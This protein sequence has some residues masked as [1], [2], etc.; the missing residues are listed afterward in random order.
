MSA[1]MWTFAYFKVFFGERITDSSG[2][3]SFRCSLFVIFSFTASDECQPAET[4]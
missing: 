3:A 2:S 4:F 1:G